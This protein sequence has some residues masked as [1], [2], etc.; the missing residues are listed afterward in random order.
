MTNDRD[1]DSSCETPPE[2]AAEGQ[3]P[4]I[5]G[6][7][8]TAAQQIMD[9]PA[10]AAGAAQ[11]ATPEVLVQRTLAALPGLVGAIDHAIKDQTGKHQPFVLL[12]F[13]EG[14]AMHSANF[15][16]EVAKAAVIELAQRWGTGEEAH[17]VPPGDEAA[18]GDAAVDK[19]GN[20]TH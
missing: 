15:Q 7:G 17:L 4:V 6:H 2:E 14:T 5:N 1:L 19:P 18:A 10:V 13:A 16:P 20:V 11:I 12:V 9:N 3:V 8:K